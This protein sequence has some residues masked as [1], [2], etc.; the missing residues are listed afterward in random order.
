MLGFIHFHPVLFI[1]SP[2]VESS[3]SGPCLYLYLVLKAVN[4]LTYDWIPFFSLFCLLQQLRVGQRQ[5]CLLH[6]FTCGF[7]HLT[8]IVGR[9]EGTC[10]KLTA[11]AVGPALSINKVCWQKPLKDSYLLYRARRAWNLP[12]QIYVRTAVLCCGI[13]PPCCSFCLVGM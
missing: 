1:N 6:T 11:P 12:Y 3:S 10:C 9:A 4:E 7:T 13:H 8:V 2:G 5:T